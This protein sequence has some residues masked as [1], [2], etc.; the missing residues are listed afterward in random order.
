MGQ[1]INHDA[2]I[3]KCINNSLKSL[4]IQHTSYIPPGKFSQ[5]TTKTLSISR[6]KWTF[7]WKGFFH[8]YEKMAVFHNILDLL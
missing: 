4:K 5:R 8:I 3:L 1:I 2:K 6:S 7:H